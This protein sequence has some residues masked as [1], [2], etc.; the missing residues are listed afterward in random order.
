MFNRYL[1]FSVNKQ[2]LRTP[3]CPSIRSIRKFDP[4]PTMWRSFPLPNGGNTRGK[5]KSKLFYMMRM[6]W[7]LVRIKDLLVNF[8]FKFPTSLLIEFK[9]QKNPVMN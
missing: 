5:F 8:S 6:P 2:K 4:W 9:Y 3:T 7:R 1:V